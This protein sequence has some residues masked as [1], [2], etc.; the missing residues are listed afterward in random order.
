MKNSFIK[1][2]NRIQL[3]FNKLKFLSHSNVKVGN[4]FK[5]GNYT[6]T[7]IHASSKIALGDQIDIRNFFNVTVGKNAELIIEDR[8]FFNNGC[9]INVLE[10][11]TIGKNTLFGE[12]VRLYDHNHKYDTHQVYHQ[13]FSTSSITIGK[14]CWLGSNVVILKGVTI[15]DNV[16][17]G[18]GCVIYK[19]VPSNSIIINE[20]EHIIKPI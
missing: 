14:N 18:A 15:G 8:V 12:N 17:I 19:N 3:K 13:E 10:K 1:L 5:L 7:I 16:I 2:M 9:S 4:N 6:T 11:V 20:Q